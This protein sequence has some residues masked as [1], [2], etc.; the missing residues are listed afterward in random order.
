MPAH[1]QSLHYDDI[2]FRLQK[3]GGAS[4]Y[5]RAVTSRV[6]DSQAFNIYHTTGSKLSRLFPVLSNADLFH[7]SHFRIPLSYKTKS[8]ATIYDFTYELGWLKTKGSAINIFQR[9]QA[10]KRADAIICISY[11]TKQDLL[12]VY[13]ELKTHPHIYVVQLATSFSLA[14]DIS[15]NVSPRMATLAK[16]IANRYIL[17]VGTRTN[18]KNFGAALQGFVGSPLPTLGYKLVC[19]G[20][21]FSDAEQNT[22]E[23][24]GIQDKTFVLE[25]ASD[26]E[27][28]YLYQNAFALLY[29]SFYEGF[30]VPLLEAMNCGCPTIAANTS[31]LPEVVGDAGILIDPKDPGTISTA[32]ER[33]LDP[34]TREE[35][36]QKGFVQA[37]SFSWEKTAQKHIE[38]YKAVGS[39]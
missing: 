14:K 7:S 5:W 2:I 10:I 8:I 38:I 18:Y 4:V 37:A 28:N 27:L 32:L 15:A 17:F 3:A 36:R 29:P 34:A 9:K 22:L 6:A 21:A 19:V 26:Q 20:P 33:L 35:H 24:L 16:A 1:R 30:G 39:L 31:S 25:Y 12:T 13:P 11:H 23:E